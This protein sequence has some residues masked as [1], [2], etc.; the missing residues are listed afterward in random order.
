[1]REP[2]PASFILSNRCLAIAFIL[3]LRVEPYPR[4]GSAEISLLE[5]ELIFIS[6]MKVVLF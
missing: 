3:F 4:D 2:L 6:R 5:W 1:M